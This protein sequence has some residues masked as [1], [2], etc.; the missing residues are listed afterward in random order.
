M[1]DRTQCVSLT[2]YSSAFEHIGHVGE[3][4]ALSKLSAAKMKLDVIEKPENRGH[5]QMISECMQRMLG[6]SNPSIPSPAHPCYEKKNS[7]ASTKMSSSK[8]C[9]KYSLDMIIKGPVQAF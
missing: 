8:N 5:A 6:N 9:L 7:R 3:F 2:Y 1:T 4:S